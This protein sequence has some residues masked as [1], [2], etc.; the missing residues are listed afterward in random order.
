MNGVM[1]TPCGATAA[2]NA[3]ATSAKPPVFTSGQYSDATERT[4]RSGTLAP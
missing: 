1:V 4:E 2:G 3:P